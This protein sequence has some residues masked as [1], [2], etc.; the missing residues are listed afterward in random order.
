MKEWDVWSFCG[1]L[2]VIMLWLFL[3]S[4]SSSCCWYCCLL[5]LL[6]LLC[7]AL[8][9]LL[10]LALLALLACLLGDNWGLAGQSSNGPVC[11]L[12]STQS[13]PRLEIWGVTNPFLCS[14][15]WWGSKHPKN[16]IIFLCLRFW[17]NALRLSMS[18]WL[19]LS[20]KSDA[21]TDHPNTDI[22][23]DVWQL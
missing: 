14:P 11:A 21:W 8:S 9:R 15:Y 5:A 19:S 4:S 22:R 20:P 6:P 10:C 16:A 2:D 23:A 18:S 3:S 7:F 1:F 13:Y 17:Q 12:T